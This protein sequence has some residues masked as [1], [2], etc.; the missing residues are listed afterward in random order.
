MYKHG[1]LVS[2]CVI[3]KMNVSHNPGFGARM[4]RELLRSFAM[5]KVRENRWTDALEK[6]SCH[7]FYYQISLFCMV[8][9][10]DDCLV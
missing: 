10:I 2:F 7:I 1:R 8:A 4:G 3:K 6:Y 9:V 5:G